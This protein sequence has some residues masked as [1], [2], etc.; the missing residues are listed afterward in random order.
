MLCLPS[1]NRLLREACFNYLIH[2][3]NSY[4]KYQI[5]KSLKTLK[6]SPKHNI[7][8]I[9]NI[10]IREST[11]KLFVGDTVEKKIFKQ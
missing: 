10:Q 6:I 2:R 9:A 8:T 3:K 4:N 1:N 11:A 5:V 7:V